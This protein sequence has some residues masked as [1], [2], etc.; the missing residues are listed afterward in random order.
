M[1]R[2]AVAFCR[3]CR[4]E[5]FFKIVA[6]VVAALVISPSADA[7]TINLSG[8]GTDV[9]FNA[10]QS[11]FTTGAT[12]R[13]TDSATYTETQVLEVAPRYSG[14]NGRRAFNIE[15]AAGA[16][17]AIVL[18]GGRVL[19]YAGGADAKVGSNSGGKI[20]VNA[21]TSGAGAPPF[22]YIGQ[23]DG[24]A[25]GTACQAVL[26][27]LDIDFTGKGECIAFGA[28][29]NDGSP[30]TTGASLTLRNVTT[31][32]GATVVESLYG[33]AGYASSVNIEDSRLLES[34]IGLDLGAFGLGGPGS[35]ANLTRSIIY[36][37]AAVG[38]DSNGV[39]GRLG[40][41][42]IS[43]CDII[44]EAA[45]AASRGVT[46]VGGSANVVN[47]IVHGDAGTVA[48]SGTGTVTD[49]NVSGRTLVNS[50]FS[51]TTSIAE[52]PA[53]TYMA[54]GLDFSNTNNFRVKT[55][56]ASYTFGADPPLGSI[57]GGPLVI[58]LT[59]GGTNRIYDAIQS[60][61]KT[62]GNILITDSATYTENKDLLVG[63]RNSGVFGQRSFN[64]SASPGQS[65]EIVMSGNV[66]ACYSGSRD[67]KLGSNEG[68][69]IRVDARA[70]NPSFGMFWYIGQENGLASG[71]ASQATLENLEI[72]STGNAVCI[73]FGA[74]GNDDTPLTTGASLTLRNVTIKGGGDPIFGGAPIKAL[75]KPSTYA[76]VVRIENCRL[77]DCANG[78][79]HGAFGLGGEQSI[80]DVSRTIIY[81]PPSMEGDINGAINRVGHLILNHCDIIN[82]AT[83][84]NV[85]AARGVVLIAAGAVLPTC[86][87]I[88]SNIYGDAGTVNF[89]GGVASVT[90]SNVSANT[91][92]NAGFTY[93]D[94]IA[95]LPADT[96]I[97]YGTDFS[98][99]DNF[100]VKQT[101]QSY[102][103]GSSPP[104]GAIGKKSTTE[105]QD[106]SLY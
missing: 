43:H 16:N 5:T 4:L 65:P 49:S 69:R 27:N 103:H 72:D 102:S 77:Y 59:G 85:A 99:E 37:S 17:P 66:M 33:P 100:R 75:Y 71:T 86:E 92:V 84:E 15:A 81:I 14:V 30:Q 83:N 10:I 21:T 88:N 94:S 7:L 52:P 58:T 12:L 55:G 93:T 60:A 91:V 40:L 73:L 50:G 87:I 11:A 78:L 2:S 38:G 24:L 76:S 53:D 63:Q 29:G 80:M 64:I 18:N 32:G 25:S 70:A 67:M 51:Y 57:G 36:S 82:E 62:G 13:I 3:S 34:V 19:F 41:M 79:E 22:W 90:D 8:G 23:E 31:T 97:T 46:L 104:L 9:I 6:G 61:T 54:Y 39:V 47:S 1:S 95:E 56:A 42:N 20:S 26:E 105:V 44:N 101:A 45:G 96:Y 68:G 106:W 48:F 35:S 89:S 28:G 74:G 98:D